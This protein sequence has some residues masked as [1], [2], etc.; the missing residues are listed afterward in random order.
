MSN[1][2]AID[3]TFIPDSAKPLSTGWPLNPRR[4]DSK[5]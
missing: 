3:A 1:M 5:N 4:G 2:L